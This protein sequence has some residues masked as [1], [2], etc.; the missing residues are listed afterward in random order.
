MLTP[1]L[2]QGIDATLDEKKELTRYERI[3]KGKVILSET[4]KEKIWKMV[5]DPNFD[6]LKQPRDH[7][8]LW[9]KCSGAYA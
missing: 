7:G 6:E 1:S 4:D 9:F 5:K 3:L 2:N 8:R